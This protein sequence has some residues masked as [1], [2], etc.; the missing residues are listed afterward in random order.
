MQYTHRDVFSTAQNSFWAGWFWC[1]LVL[2][3]FFISLCPHRQHGFLWGHFSSGETKQ[4]CSRWDW[5]N[6]EGGSRGVKPFLVKNCWTV[7]VVWA[8]VLV[9]HPSGNGQMC[10]K[11]LQ[12]NWSQ[13]QPLTPPACT[14]IQMD[15]W[16]SHLRGEAC[17]IRGPPSRR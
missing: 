16:N 5:L 8:G 9:N 14:L 13:M 6:R 11:S 2:L 12:K 7:S 10:W 1:L 17:T 15:Y 3:L 4:S